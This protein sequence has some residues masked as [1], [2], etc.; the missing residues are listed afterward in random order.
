MKKKESK[1]KYKIR[2]VLNGNE[3]I[4]EVTDNFYSNYRVI[5][6]FASMC[7]EEFTSQIDFNDIC[8][9][10][11]KILKTVGQT[12]EM[13]KQYNLA[14]RKYETKLIKLF[15]KVFETKIK[16]K[17][18]YEK[19]FVT[20]EDD[21]KNNIVAQIEGTTGFSEK[22]NSNVVKIHFNFI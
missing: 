4:I 2:L 13:E 10:F 22:H 7:I 15:E 14:Y 19:S 16:R 17:D 5:N 6:E 21:I 9:S 8:I 1:K 18:F 3:K 12:T 20:D 11:D